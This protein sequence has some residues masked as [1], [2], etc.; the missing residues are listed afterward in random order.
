MLLVL[1]EVSTA[2]RR[3]FF[4][5]ILALSLS[6]FYLFVTI[7]FSSLMVLLISRLFISFEDLYFLL[8]HLISLVIISF[9]F[10]LHFYWLSSTLNS[11]RVSPINK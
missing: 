5:L 9:V 10:F 8:R 6:S 11:T 1:L 3:K 4:F 2:F 7:P